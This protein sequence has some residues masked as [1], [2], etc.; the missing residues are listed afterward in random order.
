MSGTDKKF[1]PFYYKMKAE[2]L[3]DLVID[4][5]R[6]YFDKLIQGD[7]GLIAEKDILPAESL[8]DIEDFQDGD[9]ARIGKDM[10]EKAVVIKLNGGLG[11]SMGMDK[12]K[13]LLEVKN[14]LTFLDITVR[15]NRKPGPGVPVVFM[16]SF[17]T[18]NDT[19]AALLPYSDFYDRSLPPDFLQHK[20]PKSMPGT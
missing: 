20:I 2:N 18:R 3:P 13:G 4:N 11:T 8:P 17:Y 15:Q 12:P 19:L 10:L 14:S 5:F 9:L 1:N 6:H 7:D 16:N